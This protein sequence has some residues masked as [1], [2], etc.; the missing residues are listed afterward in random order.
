MSRDQH[1]RRWPGIDLHRPSTLGRVVHDHDHAAQQDHGQP[2]RQH[3]RHAPEL[4]GHQHVEQADDPQGGREDRG[5]QDEHRE[6]RL[7]ADKL[8]AYGLSA[9]IADARFAKPLDTEIVARLA[10]DH[11]V[12]VTIE[13]GSVGGFGSHVLQFLS[14]QGLLDRGLKVR[15]MFLPD[16]FIDQNKPDAMYHQ[17][18]LDAEG[19]VTTVFT[20]LG[21]E[22]IAESGERA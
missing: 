3:R 12:L 11:E 16:I 2:G 6:C 14:E 9:T 13:E 4:E 1:Q 20:A 22:R 7:A 10:K 18:G 8:S 19:I 5:E 21:R 17:A 15:T